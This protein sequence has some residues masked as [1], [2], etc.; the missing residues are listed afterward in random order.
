[1]TTAE[2]LA[3][4]ERA[5][6]LVGPGVVVH[7]TREALAALDV[8]LGAGIEDPAGLDV[9][10]AADAMAAVLTIFGSLMALVG[11]ELVR[12]RAEV[13]FRYLMDQVERIERQK[14]GSDACLGCDAP[15][16][17][18]GWKLGRKCCP[19]C[20]HERPGGVANPEV[21]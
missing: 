18:D 4:Y 5:A 8:L 7:K 15:N 10:E 21:N 9:E 19:D 20:S 6:A 17:S 16:C 3:W 11:P 14:S 2:M 13:R 1:M 12:E